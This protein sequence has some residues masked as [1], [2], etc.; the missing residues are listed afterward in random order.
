[1]VALATTM[2]VAKAS[3]VHASSWRVNNDATK[4]AHFVD[5]NAAMA[6]EEVQAGDTL[7]LDPG[8]SE[9]EVTCPLS[10][11]ILFSPKRLSP[12][13]RQSRAVW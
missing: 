2:L 6:S 8:I 7:Y 11:G 9:S 5:I 1:M 4:K 13:L 3:T 10:I 12:S